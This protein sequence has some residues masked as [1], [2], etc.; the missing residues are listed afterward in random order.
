MTAPLI[1]AAIRLFS[2]SVQSLVTASRGTYAGPA[3]GIGELNHALGATQGLDVAGLQKAS[4]AGIQKL[5]GLPS[6]YK[7]LYDIFVDTA[8]GF[9]VEGIKK[10]ID[11]IDDA[12]SGAKDAKKETQAATEAIKEIDE[13]HC[14][15]TQQLTEQLLNVITTISDTLNS[16]DPEKQLPEFIDLVKSGSSLIDECAQAILQLSQSRDENIEGCFQKLVDHCQ[17]I[18]DQGA[19]ETSSEQSRICEQEKTPE[20]TKN[21]NSAQIGQGQN[22]CP[23]PPT[24]TATQSRSVPP[25]AEPAVIPTTPEVQPP[26]VNALS[27]ATQPAAAVPTA[28]VTTQVPTAPA[29]AMTQN[30]HI[31]LGTNSTMPAMVPTDNPSVAGTGTPQYQQIHYGL[32][33]T[34]MQYTQPPSQNIGADAS[35]LG[36]NSL[37]STDTGAFSYQ[38]SA[39]AITALSVQGQQLCQTLS[40]IGARF[41]STGLDWVLEQA[42]QYE[43]SLTQLDTVEQ[44]QASADLATDTSAN[45]TTP[46]QPSQPEEKNIVTQ[47]E[48][49]AH[50][51]A[52]PPAATPADPP[53]QQKP[54][55][56]SAHATQAPPQPEQSVAQPQ[57][58][59]E[60]TCAAET[61][62]IVGAQVRTGGKISADLSQSSDISVKKAGAW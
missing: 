34:P 12:I 5:G 6:L 2:R 59:D 17:A 46:S 45:D 42:Q 27:T 50:I 40:G 29:G 23:A 8:G 20:P 52:D 22:T 33:P 53:V 35:L 4:A 15:R 30:I 57:P 38:G 26:P 25:P 10:L 56:D 11:K 7:P 39:E 36:S 49:A 54:E 48:P 51:P 19:A 44:E 61:K 55:S 1:N 18:G 21:Q 16:L 41:M 37:L 14:A 43:E 47:P 28:P 60:K 58:N 13:E 31:S 32:Q 9:L 24:G 3:I 62:P